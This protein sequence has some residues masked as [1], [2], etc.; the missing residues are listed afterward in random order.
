MSALFGG[1]LEEEY[2]LRFQWRC[3]CKELIV[4]FATFVHLA[5][6]EASTHIGFGTVTLVGHNPAAMHKDVIGHGLHMLKGV[7][8]QT[9]K[10]AR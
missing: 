5:T 3:E 10:H 1:K 4:M 6:H 2:D 7:N 9:P 8:L